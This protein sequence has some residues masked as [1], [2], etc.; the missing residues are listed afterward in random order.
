MTEISFTKIPPNESFEMKIF[1]DQ[2][3]LL[4]KSEYLTGKISKIN[5][6]EST[7]LTDE[8]LQTILPHPLNTITINPCLPS[9]REELILQSHIIYLG[10]ADGPIGIELAPL[11]HS[12]ACGGLKVTDIGNQN[13]FMKDDVIVSIN[14]IEI[15]NINANRAVELLINTTQRIVTIIRSS[16][17]GRVQTTEPP[18]QSTKDFPQYL[19]QNI[20][21]ARSK[22][23]KY[24]PRCSLTSYRDYICDV[25]K[26]FS[27]RP[28]FEFIPFLDSIK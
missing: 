14:N 5:H 21:I 28:S 7:N 26:R 13:M 24:H 3:I 9:S 10:L 8:D 20:L 2:N 11:S 19:P 17:P 16:T 22:S 23:K 18:L 25:E 15:E 27:S 4:T 12:E 1:Q 6:L